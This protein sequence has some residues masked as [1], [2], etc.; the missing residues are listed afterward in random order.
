MLTDTLSY[1]EYLPKRVAR[2][3]EKGLSVGCYEWVL[4]TRK[5]S[6]L[7]KGV[8]LFLVTQILDLHFLQCVGFAVDDASYFVNA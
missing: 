4:Y 6:H 5:Y 2:L 8:L 1:A 7:V 3:I